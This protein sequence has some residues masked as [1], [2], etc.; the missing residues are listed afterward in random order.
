M[1][2]ANRW[3]RFVVVMCVAI[4]AACATLRGQNAETPS[5]TIDILVRQQMDLAEKAPDRDTRLVHLHKA[6]TIRPDDPGNLAIV[7]RI[8]IE[9]S[10]RYDPQYPEQTPRRK[11]AMVIY[12]K[13]V[14][15]YHH[16]DYY[17]SEPVDRSY[18]PQLMVPGAYIHLACLYRGL[19]GDSAKARDCLIRA[20]ECL[21]QTYE[22]RIEDWSSEPAPPKPNPNSPFG[23]LSAMGKWEARTA[24]WNKRRQDAANGDVFGPLEMESVKAAVRQYGYSHGRQKAYEV[25]AVMGEIIK[26]FPGTPMAKVAEEHAQRAVT[27]TDDELYEKLPDTLTDM[28]PLSQLG[29]TDVAAT[30]D[31]TPAPTSRDSSAHAA[32]PNARTSTSDGSNYY[33]PLLWV[34]AGCI[35]VGAVLYVRKKKN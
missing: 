11:E 2:T 32:N 8:A 28:P 23:G 1:T 24:Q 31:S 9:L 6:L 15:E 34:L 14:K 27:M 7:Y 18:D 16:M 30:P 13:L 12:E 19:H 5:E 29:Q 17:S 26:M 4:A 20:M 22:K 21:K 3:R 35:I 10:Q 25:P 33:W